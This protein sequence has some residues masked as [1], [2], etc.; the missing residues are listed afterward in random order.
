M[1]EW[2]GVS[3]CST[4]PSE[5]PTSQTKTI[6]S[7][8]AMVYLNGKKVGI[9]I[10]P[11]KNCYDDALLVKK[12]ENRGNGALSIT[13]NRPGLFITLSGKQNAMAHRD[14]LPD[15]LVLLLDEICHDYV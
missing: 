2:F 11:G 9:Q 10:F 4:R 14:I 8:E 15:N 6:C 3:E 5:T 12:Q 7:D 13:A 1:L